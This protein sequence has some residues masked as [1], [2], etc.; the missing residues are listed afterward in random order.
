MSND[1]SHGLPPVM[2]RTVPEGVVPLVAVEG[3]ARE[4]GRT[5]ASI[6]KE[7]YPGYRRYLDPAYSWNK[8][9]SPDAK[10]LFDKYAPHIPEVFQGIAEVGGPPESAPTAE[11]NAGCTSFGVSGSVTLD[12]HPVS[13]QTKDT[14]IKSAEQ[15]IVLRMRIAGAPAILTLAYPGE[16]MGY[17]FW[18]TG[19][20]IFRNSLFSEKGGESGLD[21]EQ[22]GYLALAMT[23][24]HEAAEVAREYGM[25]SA[26]NCLI[27]DGDGESLS[28]EYNVGGVG[29]VHAKEG[30]ATHANHPEGAETAPHE[31]YEYDEERQNSRYRMHGLWV[32]IDKERGRFTAQKAMQLMADHTHYP[33]G[34]CRHMANRSA[35]IGTTAAV[36]AEPTRGKLHVTRSNPCC[37]W[38]VTYE[39]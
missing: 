10:K 33:L 21:R 22:W 31:H 29:I 36:V 16:V 7:K 14:P 37:N 11:G 12:G 6:V 39:M 34:I 13:G 25:R 4:C 2:P 1:S 3:D 27:S 5:Y 19:T 35:R 32:M 8:G 17:G 38:P 24:V 26:G 15:Y 30:I 23:S 9:L 20:S 18:S 28:V